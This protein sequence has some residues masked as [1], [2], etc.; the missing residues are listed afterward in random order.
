[1]LAASGLSW[2][3]LR[4]G[5]YASSRLMMHARGLKAG[6]L[7][8]PQDGKVA[9]T[10]HDDLA[11]AAAGLLAGIKTIDGPTPPLT[12]SLALDLADLAQLAG[13]I[14]GSPVGRNVVSDDDAAWA[15]RKAGVTEGAVSMMLGYYRAARAGEFAAT[16]PLLA[17]LLGRAPVTMRQFLADRIGQGQAGQGLRLRQRF[18]S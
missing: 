13:E 2:T 14:T 18:G 11:A 12:G 16:D 10:T 9:W 17:R 7:A 8:A 4:H 3:A 15:A 5:F 6:M 1:M